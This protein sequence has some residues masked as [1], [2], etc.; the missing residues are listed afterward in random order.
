[1]TNKAVFLIILLLPAFAFAQ[2]AAELD[3]MLETEA[4][5][6]AA[7]A[8]F[9]L[10]SA[11]LLPPGLSGIEAER[12]AYDLALSNGWLKTGAG[13]TIDL[14]DTAFL[15]MKAFDFKGG[16]MYSIFGNPRYAYRE[17]IYHK[18]IQG[19]A[20]PSMTVSGPRLLHII[21]RASSH[22]AEG[23]RGQ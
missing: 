14:R 7:A 16:I 17:M 21:G 12:A 18:L 1:M 15:V 9:V 10:E 3:I 8:R 11:E 4:V 23:N 13:E 6:A 19:R 22:A 2:T 20:Y 5:S